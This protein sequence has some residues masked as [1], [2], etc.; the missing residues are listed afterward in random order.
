MSLGTQPSG[1]LKIFPAGGGKFPLPL[2]RSGTVSVGAMANFTPTLFLEGG[3]RPLQQ[4][5]HSYQVTVGASDPNH[6]NVV[7]HKQ[8]SPRAPQSHG[9]GQFLV[10]TCPLQDWP[11]IQVECSTRIPKRARGARIPSAHREGGE[12]LP[13]NPFPRVPLVK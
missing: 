13:S 3:A 8:K 6:T 4:T 5:D 7:P 1:P 11:S 2:G 12:P 10:G 9:G